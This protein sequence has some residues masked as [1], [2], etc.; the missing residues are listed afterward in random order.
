MPRLFRFNS[1]LLQF[2]PMSLFPCSLFAIHSKIGLHGL[3]S[4]KVKNL[5]RPA[6]SSDFARSHYNPPREL[7]QN[8]ASTHL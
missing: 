5:E 6:C 4:L 3:L 1:H 8:L 7:K 2:L